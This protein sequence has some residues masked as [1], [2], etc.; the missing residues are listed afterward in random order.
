[1]NGTDERRFEEELTEALA[2]E[3]PAE[4]L[5]AL[6]LQ[7]GDDPERARRIA[8]ARRIVGE[9]SA[10]GERLGTA[11]VP[12]LGRLGLPLARGAWRRWA[13][14]AATAAAAAGVVVALCLR[15][16]APTEPPS[17]LVAASQ[18]DERPLVWQVPELTPVSL[19][20]EFST[21]EVTLPSMSSLG[22]VWQ[23][24]PVPVGENPERRI[25]DETQESDGG[26]DGG[27][28][29]RSGDR[30]RLRDGTG[31]TQPA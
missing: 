1:M 24:P 18:P 30:L 9:L 14:P 29:G 21:P 19:G 26:V 5:D 20:E 17:P 28:S 15:R 11:D 3:S 2:A 16:P 27:G 13:I 25:K 7:Y 8:E 4:V 12:P 6:V 31:G 23:V 10:L 22:V